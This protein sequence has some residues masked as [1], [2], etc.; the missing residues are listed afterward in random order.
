MIGA[1]HISLKLLELSS[2]HEI[3]FSLLF[4]YHNVTIIS[5]AIMFCKNSNYHFLYCNT[6]LSSKFHL[7][8]DLKKQIFCIFKSQYLKTQF[9]NDLCSA[10]WFK[11]ALIDY[12]I[13]ISNAPLILFSF[14]LYNF[15][16]ILEE[17]KY[18]S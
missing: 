16:F 4:N 5:L 14:G 17:I 2:V 12:E 18:F 6:Q 9:P 7:T 1:R 10:I 8:C 13:A 3:K 11:I 15:D